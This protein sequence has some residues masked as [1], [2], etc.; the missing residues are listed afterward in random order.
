M[1]Y[2]ILAAGGLS[3]IITL[4]HV[5]MGGPEVARPLLAAGNL[6]KQPKYVAYYCWHLVSISLGLMSLLFLWPALWDGSNDLAIM[7]SI[8]A[9]LFALW[10]IGL[11]QFSKADLTFTELPQGWLFVPIAIFG[12]WGSLF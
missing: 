9:T 8:M 2:P 1:A 6:E 4:I 7:G 3:A 10:G 11:L 12:F 5:F